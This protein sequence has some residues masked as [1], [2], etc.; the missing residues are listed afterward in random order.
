MAGQQSTIIFTGFA[1]PG[2]CP[3]GG[4]GAGDRGI[5][6]NGP[7]NTLQLAFFAGLGHIPACVHALSGLTTAVRMRRHVTRKRHVPVTRRK[8]QCPAGNTPGLLA[9]E[10]LT[11]PGACS[12]SQV[13]TDIS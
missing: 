5:A 11:A 4:I 9:A 7:G 13:G 1:W 2:R 10:A 6:Q 3:D 12:I 8:S